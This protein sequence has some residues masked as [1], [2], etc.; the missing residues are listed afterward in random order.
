[1][2]NLVKIVTTDILNQ[3]FQLI[4][5]VRNKKHIIDIFDVII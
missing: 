1:M 5:K 3:I 2:V 4:S